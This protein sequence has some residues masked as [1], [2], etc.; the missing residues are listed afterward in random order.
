ML[1]EA[2]PDITRTPTVRELRA[3]RKLEK[4]AAAKELRDEQV[5]ATEIDGEWWAA[6]EVGLY[7]HD[8]KTP[9]DVRMKV[10]HKHKK[11]LADRHERTYG[12]R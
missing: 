9:K 12:I 10:N 5:A 8:L 7:A 11:V 2:G 1:R 4:E 3:Q 6:L